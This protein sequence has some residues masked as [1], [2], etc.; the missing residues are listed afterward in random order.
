L[1]FILSSNFGRDGPILLRALKSR[2]WP[3]HVAVLFSCWTAVCTGSAPAAGAFLRPGA[4]LS[5]DDS[6]AVF[7]HDVEARVHQVSNSP[8]I[9]QV[10]EFLS[11]EECEFL[12]KHG[13]KQLQP[14][15]TID[16]ET[17]EYVPDTVRTNRQMYISKEDCRN[18]PEIANIVRRLH[19]L[20]R[21]P[22]GH[23]EQVQVG[24]YL[25]GEKYDCH[26]DSEV[27]VNVVRPATII[28]YIADGVTGGDTIFPMG[29]TCM[30]LSRCCEGNVT[31]PVKRFHPKKGRALLFYSHDLDGNLNSHALHGSCPVEGGEKWIIQAWFRST[32][33]P[34]SPHYVFDEKSTGDA[35]VHSKEL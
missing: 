25:V 21:I 33:Y 6:V 4:E 12:R 10:D 17:G 14:S 11:D 13:A 8:R 2:M 30:P 29:A 15:L 27:S 35:E 23:G 26:F 18:Q 32:L 22:I 24:R 34:E 31:F 1:L 20:A 3:C 16:R 28:V 5:F 7:S 9:Y 19:R